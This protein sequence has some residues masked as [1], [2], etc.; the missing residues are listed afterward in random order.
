MSFTVFYI[1]IRYI[2]QFSDIIKI[3]DEQPKEH[4]THQGCITIKDNIKRWNTY[5]SV[6]QLDNK[7]LKKPELE[8]SSRI[9]VIII[10]LHTSVQWA[11]LLC[12]SLVLVA[13]YAA[14][15]EYSIQE[16]FDKIAVKISQ[17]ESGM[18]TVRY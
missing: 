15:F 16:T 13:A 12:H 9:F 5:S 2:R 10:F 4:K 3:L 1:I 7:F 6:K 11:A 17:K 18:L 8:V 14:Y